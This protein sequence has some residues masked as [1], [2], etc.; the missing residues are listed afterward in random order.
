MVEAGEECLGV[1]NR[2]RC[3][4][5]YVCVCVCMCINV[6][7]C[8]HV[9]VRVCACV[10]RGGGDEDERGEGGR[11]KGM[12]QFPNPLVVS[13]QCSWTGWDATPT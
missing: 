5:M 6:E 3:V 9:C 12:K 10:C 8:A 1:R 4:Y 2:C 13:R 11:R 7:S